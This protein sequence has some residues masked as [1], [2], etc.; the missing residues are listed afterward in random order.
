MPEPTT[1]RL[2]EW[3]R[4]SLKLVVKGLYEKTTRE[5]LQF[6]S[7]TYNRTNEEINSLCNLIKLHTFLVIENMIKKNDKRLN[8]HDRIEVLIKLY[9]AITILISISFAMEIESYESIQRVINS[10]LNKIPKIK[11]KISRHLPE[12]EPEVIRLYN[13]FN[14]FTEIVNE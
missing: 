9:S 10:L 8:I 2:Q 7:L 13:I 1:T 3:Q 11:I 6:I 14:M 4:I 12:T 5:E